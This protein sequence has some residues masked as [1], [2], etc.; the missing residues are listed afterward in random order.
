LPGSIRIS[1]TQPRTSPDGET[2]KASVAT[3]GGAAAPAWAVCT[4]TG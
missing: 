2:P 3:R 4:G 1:A